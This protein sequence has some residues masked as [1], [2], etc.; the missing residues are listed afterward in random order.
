[1]QDILI[2]GIGAVLA[3]TVFLISLIELFFTVR[4][5]K[6]NQQ[7][8]DQIKALKVSYNQSVNQMVHEDENR[9]QDADK[10]LEELTSHSDGER[11][12]IE[13]AYKAKIAQLEAK[14]EKALSRAEE[15]AHKMED[16]ARMKAEEYL[17]MRKKE[18][19]AELMN[20]V[21][22]VTKKVLPEGLDYTV[23]KELVMRALQDAK[24]NSVKD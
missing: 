13:A 22:T 8:A 4:R 21:L 16:E 18:V 17:E 9:L 12:D 6:V 1:M 24:T 7:I 5:R 2:F 20:L 23:Q 11:K 14:S 3:G 19:E 15:H 10:T